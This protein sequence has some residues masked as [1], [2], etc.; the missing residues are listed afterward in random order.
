MGVLYL[1]KKIWND[2]S[3]LTEGNE[4]MPD[5][6]Q[7]AAFDTIYQNDKEIVYVSQDNYYVAELE[8]GKDVVYYCDSATSCIVIISVGYSEEYKK[9]LA[10]ISHLS[11]PGR[12][13]DYFSKVETIFNGEIDIYAAGANPAYPC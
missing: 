9:N 4:I 3:A 13:D 5:K 12:F 10:V 8:S 2:K 6:S 7:E 1:G 11:R